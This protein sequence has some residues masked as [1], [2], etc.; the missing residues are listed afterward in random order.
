MKPIYK[1]LTL[2]AMTLQVSVSLHAQ[3]TDGTATSQINVPAEV[4]DSLRVELVAP[5]ISGARDLIKS[6]ECT[7]SDNTLS[8]ELQT[9]DWLKGGVYRLQVSATFGTQ[10]QVIYAL[11]VTVPR[12]DAQASET[13]EYEDTVTVVST[14]GD[15]SGVQIT[16]DQE[17]IEDSKNPVAGGAVFNA[18]ADKADKSELPD[19]SDYATQQD[20]SDGLA[21]KQNAGNYADGNLFGY[22]ENGGIRTAKI[23]GS[24][25]EGNNTIA[26]GDNSHAEGNY[27][28]AS[29]DNSHAEGSATIAS[30]YSSHA[31]GNYSEASGENSHAEGSSTIASGDN[32]HA[33]GNNTTA[34]GD[35]SHASGV[36][37]KAARNSQFVC[38]KFNVESQ[39]D[40]YAFI[41]G[42]GTSVSN[43]SNAFAIDWNGNLVLFNNGAPVV[44]TP[45]KLAQLIV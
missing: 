25:Q 27:S 45:A 41:V 1:S 42:N 33:E 32:S 3:V 24:L 15:G 16:V 38:G 22:N 11:D 35:N 4:L 18:L 29:G 40:D 19:M 26:S 28:E 21:G 36:G 37:T 39:T 6:G 9:D 14:F 2:A 7:V 10:M 30:G 12:Y 8:I 5:N 44:L 23:S 13:Q 20:L 17:V 31:E 43:M 34:S